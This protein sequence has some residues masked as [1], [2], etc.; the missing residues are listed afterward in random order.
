ML[1]CPSYDKIVL[2]DETVVPLLKLFY[3]CLIEDRL[4]RIGITQALTEAA[5]PKSAI[6]PASFALGVRLDRYGSADMIKE[7]SRLGFCISYIM[8]CHSVALPMQFMKHGEII[9][10]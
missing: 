8:N 7:V 4:K 2:D 5:R 1:N 3:E 6:L 9:I 10:K